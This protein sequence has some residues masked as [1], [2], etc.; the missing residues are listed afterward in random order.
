MSKL[1]KLETKQVLRCE[2]CGGFHSEEESEIVVIRI[3]KGKNCELKNIFSENRTTA[4]ISNFSN[5]QQDREEKFI[6]KGESIV[7][8]IFAPKEETEEI[9]V[10]PA[11]RKIVPPPGMVSM[12][13]PGGMPGEATEK[14]MA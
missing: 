9:S 3:V 7:P 2:A 13:T 11:K 10:L 12:M 8:S 1:P 5:R 14:R 4:P 6:P